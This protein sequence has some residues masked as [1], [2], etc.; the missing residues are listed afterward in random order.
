M[1]NCRQRRKFI[2]SNGQ[3]NKNRQPVVKVTV[4]RVAGRA[5]FVV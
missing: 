4:E 2:S 3:L 1:N 5:K